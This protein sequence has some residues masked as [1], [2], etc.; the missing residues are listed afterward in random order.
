MHALYALNASYH[1]KHGS[2]EKDPH[3]EVSSGYN[4]IAALKRACMM[5]APQISLG[6]FTNMNAMLLF[7]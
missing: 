1:H 6:Q 7:L 2:R 5:Q 4:L 3:C